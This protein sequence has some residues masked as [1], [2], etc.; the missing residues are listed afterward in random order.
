MP[1]RE[2]TY[3]FIIIALPVLNSVLITNE[4][5]FAILLANSA[6]IGTLFVLKHGCVFHYELSQ[7]LT[8]ERIELI[9]PE[10]YDLQLDD[11]INRT[12]F[13]I[14]RFEMGRID[15]LRDTAEIR[16]FHDDRQSS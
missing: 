6:I 3:L 14:K 7:R 11:S 15:F 13:D 2:M 4:D 12:N 10:H 1:T 16:I 9:K 5:W 8:Y